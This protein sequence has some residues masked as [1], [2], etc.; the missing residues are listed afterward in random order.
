MKIKI[1]TKKQFT[2]EILYCECC[3][4][5]LKRNFDKI[6]LNLCFDCYLKLQK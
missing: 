1:E 6:I 4:V 2:K 5:E 3:G